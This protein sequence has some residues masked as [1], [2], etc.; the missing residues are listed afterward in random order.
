MAT[1][2]TDIAEEVLADIPEWAE[3]LLEPHRNKVLYG[4]RSG[5]KS[6]SVARVLLALGHTSER[7]LRILCAREIQ[8]SIKDSVHKLLSDQAA[9][10]G[11]P[12]VV[13]DNEIRHPN[14]TTFIFRGLRTNPSSFKS[15]ES[16]D[17]VWVEEADRVSAESWEK[18]LPTIRKKGSEVWV[19]FNPDLEDDPT[20]KLF[21]TQPLPGTWS[22]KV[23]ADENPW[24]TE[25]SRVLRAHAYAV[26]PD[27]ADHVWGGNCRKA[28]DAQ[29][30]RGKW[31]VEEFDPKPGWSG[32]YHG[33]DF[34]FA[35][36]PTVACKLWVDTELKRVDGKVV[37]FDTLYV[38]REAHKIGLELD[39]TASYVLD[40]IPSADGYVMRADSSRPESISYLKRHGLPKI[41]GVDKWPGSIEDGIAHLRQYVRIV[42]HP[43]C[44]RA[45]FEAKNYSYEVDKR[46]GDVLPKVRD[47]HNDFWDSARYAL[48]PLVKP[49]RLRRDPRSSLPSSGSFRAA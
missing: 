25:E 45:I 15:F 10:M 2:E 6:W 43:R 18:L 40:R 36:N 31:F 27:A 35:L 5:A 49:R 11:L 19:T 24:L 21:I 48:G 22:R 34:G 47:L 1:I 39:D 37:S 38:E 28:S 9:E 29:I 33:L 17:I 7:S 23:N 41:V 44:E 8:N 32:P 42:I 20:Y 26:D 12:Y 4:G 14:G 3:G 13:L 46:T 16:I 30:L